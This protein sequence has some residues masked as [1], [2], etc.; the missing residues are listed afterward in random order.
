MKKVLSFNVIILLLLLCGCNTT[1][2]NTR[3]QFLFDT[4]VTLTADCDSEVLDGAFAL[5]GDYEKLLSRTK[6]GSDIS[7]LNTSDGFCEVSEH[8]VNI[9]ERS[10][11]YSRLSQGKFDITIHPVSSLW[12]FGGNT[13]PDRNEITEALKNVDYQSIEIDGKSV[14][15]KGK[16]IDL[17]G[18]AKG[19]IADRLK[20]YFIHNDT[21]SGIINLGGNLVV[22]GEQDYNLGICKP[23]SDDISV[24]LRLRNKS[25]VTSGIYQRYIEKNGKIY[26]HILDT[27][28]GYGCNTDLY[29][30]TVISDSSLDGDALATVCILSGLEGARDIIEALPDT[31]AVFINNK[32]KIYYTSGLIRDGDII[33]LK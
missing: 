27:E 6:Q 8:T 11:Y 3:T 2:E 13:L 29:S 14:N 21:P 26:H 7:I 31:E 33:T 1:K 32:G 15:L 17:G 19:Y 23:F 9:I 5:C 10:I 28:T 4:V 22:F 20:E 12:D 18:I 30:A 25:V 16:E 24:T